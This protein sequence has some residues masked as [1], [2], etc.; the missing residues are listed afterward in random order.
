MH[1]YGPSLRFSEIYGPSDTKNLRLK[2][3]NFLA[4]GC[5]GVS[6]QIIDVHLLEELSSADSSFE[7]SHQCFA[8]MSSDGRAV[9]ASSVLGVLQLPWVNAYT[10]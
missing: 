3:A 1:T 6:G 7:A 4:V 10:I 5:W 2:S 8:G 9:F